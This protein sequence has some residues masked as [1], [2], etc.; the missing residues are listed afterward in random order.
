VLQWTCIEL[1]QNN[2]ARYLQRKTLNVHLFIW[3]N[4]LQ[5]GDG[6]VD[7]GSHAG[8]DLMWAQTANDTQCEY[9]SYVAIPGE[10]TKTTLG[11]KNN[12]QA[13]RKHN[14]VTRAIRPT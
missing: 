3:F 12:M 8:T 2:A 1:N 10:V 4:V 6:F 5:H 11:Y 9:H 7:V 14:S 13:Y